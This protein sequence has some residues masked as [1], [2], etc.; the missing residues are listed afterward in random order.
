MKSYVGQS[1]RSARSTSYTVDMVTNDP[2]PI[3]PEI[4]P[5]GT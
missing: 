2:F 4:S 3:L 5:S 1:R